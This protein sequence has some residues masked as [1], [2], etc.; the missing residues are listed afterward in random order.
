[1]D[2]TRA[3]LDRFSDR[4][5]TPRRIRGG[6]GVGFRQRAARPRA[7]PGGSPMSAAV[8]LREEVRDFVARRRK[9][10]IAGRWTDSASGKAFPTYD[11][12]KGEVLAEVAEGDREDIDRAVRAA[13]AAFDGGPW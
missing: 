5:R 8:P 10:L 12:S 3:L 1:M 7:P 9:L 2:G 13:R 4:A 11:P 6:K